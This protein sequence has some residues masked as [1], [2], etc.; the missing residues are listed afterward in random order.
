M[1]RRTPG[2]NTGVVHDGPAKRRRRL[3]AEFTGT[4]G[5]EVIRW[6]GHNPADP[7]LARSMARRAPG[8][9]TG[10]VHGCARPE[11]GRRRR[12]PP[13]TGAT[14]RRGDRNMVGRFGH[15]CSPVMATSDRT[16]SSR[17]DNR[18]EGAVIRG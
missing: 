15:S 17:G 11:G 5:R 1:T 18:R 3:V 16:G 12:R 9:N 7:R 8:C 14:L 10:M 4:R 2:C 13:V 6:F